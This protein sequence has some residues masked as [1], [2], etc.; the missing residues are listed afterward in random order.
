MGTSDLVEQLL[1]A[2]QASQD[3]LGALRIDP[4]FQVR[5]EQQAKGA[6]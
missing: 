5:W 4:T 2:G 1:R 6:A 3:G